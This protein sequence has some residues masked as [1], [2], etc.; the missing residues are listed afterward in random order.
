MFVMKRITDKLIA[1]LFSGRRTARHLHLGAYLLLTTNPRG[2]C[3]HALFSKRWTRGLEKFHVL[4]KI[5]QRRKSTSQDLNHVFSCWDICSHAGFSFSPDGYFYYHRVPSD[6]S[7]ANQSPRHS[8]D[9]IF[10]PQGLGAYC[11]LIL[12]CSLQLVACLLP[13]LRSLSA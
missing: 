2:R 10:P 4:P 12:P 6:W 3:H 7:H 13:L 5:T 11:S 1:L 9:S 8:W